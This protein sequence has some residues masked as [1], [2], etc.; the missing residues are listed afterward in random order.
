MKVNALYL[1]IHSHF[2]FILLVLITLVVGIVTVKEIQALASFTDEMYQHAL[3]VNQAISGIQLD[4]D[5]MHHLT[6]AL[7]LVKKPEE[8]EKIHILLNQYED[9]VYKNFVLLFGNF[10]GNQA[11]IQKAYRAFIE[12]RQLQNEVEQKM[13]HADKEQAISLNATAENL[14]HYTLTEEIR[15]IIDI[16]HHETSR[17]LADAQ[18]TKRQLLI[19]LYIVLLMI[20]ITNLLAILITSKVTRKQVKEA[21]Q[22]LQTSEARYQDMVENQAELICRFLPDTTLTF[23]NEA[24][25]HC[26]GVRRADILGKPFLSLIPDDAHEATLADIRALTHDPQK[27]RTV[28]HEQPAINAKGEIVWQQW[29]NRA[30]LNEAGQVVELQAVGRDITERKEMEALLQ[31]NQARL[32]Q[33][34]A[35][36][37]QADIKLQAALEASEEAKRIAEKANQA[38]SLFLANMS[39]EIRTP[40]NAILGFT[41]LLETLVTDK[42]Q[43]SYLESIKSSSKNLLILINDILDLSKIEAGKLFIQRA[44]VDVFSLFEELRQ[45]FS[46]KVTEKALAFELDIASDLPHSLLLDEVRLRQVLLNLV[47]NAIK[48]TE[49]GAIRL[50]AQWVKV[51]QNIFNLVLAVTD[52]GIGIS[53]V[54]QDKIF[55]LFEQQMHQ[56]TRKYGG[57]GLGLAISKRL[58]EMMNGT[59][60]V[61]ST[62]NQGSRFEIVLHHVVM[63]TDPAPVQKERHFQH[64]AIIFNAATLLV[65]DDI[66]SNRK[67]IK[68]YFYHTAIH[69]IEA[70]NGREALHYIEKYQPDVILMDIRMPI[71][72]GYE[73]AKHIKTQTHSK[74]IPIIAL[75]A[76][77]MEQDKE[78]ILQSGFDAYLTKPLKISELYYEL[79]RFLNYFTKERALEMTNQQTKR[80]SLQDA[81]ATLLEKLP[82]IVA[83]LEHEYM[84]TWKSVKQS[85]SFDEIARFGKQMKAFGQTY[86]LKVLEGFGDDLINYVNHFDILNIEST[87]NAYTQLI[88]EIKQPTIQ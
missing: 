70:E 52:T 9:N 19:K 36:R 6:D 40:M 75:T 11:L 24:Y 28:T 17:F 37:Q 31:E 44:S 62:V 5:A 26:F 22:A 15:Q 72:N 83:K 77:A 78:K 86:S 69:V 57:T 25:C 4:M 59:I 60:A 80:I 27:T 56:D 50:S 76:S 61:T 2:S 29:S 23:V 18:H 12:W 30:I 74:T 87:L 48:F 71:M 35:E 3:V 7:L 65:V 20:F 21:K 38:K 81:P 73:A 16:T 85:H 58:V 41:D 14:Y 8:I 64:Q 79:T 63:V 66:E 42:K 33:D 34:I 10:L 47:G 32:V 82:E 67:L 54:S 51:D 49:T 84:H 55:D 39:H 43:K 46:L 53:E 88:Q 1:K 45:V 13:R 68:E